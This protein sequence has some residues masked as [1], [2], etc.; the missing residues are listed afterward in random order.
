MVTDKL[1]INICNLGTHEKAFKIVAYDPFFADEIF[2][3]VK[4]NSIEFSKTVGKR[5]KTRNEKK[6]YTFS[7]HPKIIIEIGQNRL[8]EEEG[9]RILKL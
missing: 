8:I 6:R 2:Y 1:Y 5:L 7:F 9:K 4:E 3:T